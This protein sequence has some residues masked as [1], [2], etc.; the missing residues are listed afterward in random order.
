MKHVK[1]VA[2]ITVIAL[3]SNA[4]FAG[5]IVDLRAVNASGVGISLNSAKEIGVLPGATG[6]IDIEVWAK[7]NGSVNA[8]AEAFTSLQGWIKETVPNFATG[9]YSAK[10]DMSFGSSKADPLTYVYE[11]PYDTSLLPILTDN[12]AH[13]KEMNSSSNTFAAVAA[14]SQT[15][16]NDVYFKI[17][18]FAYTLNAAP[19]SLLASTSIDFY[20]KT[21]APGASYKI[22]GAT[23]TGSAAGYVSAGPIGIVTVVPEPSTFVLLGM[24]SL[25]LLAIRRRK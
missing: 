15:V 24:A 23:K 14:G 5:L 16:E 8:T 1:L 12:A 21:T 3:I 25:A 4:A 18:K 7:V 9:E 22:D 10:G 19:G 11:A 17:G 20:P 6:K 2:L 13:D